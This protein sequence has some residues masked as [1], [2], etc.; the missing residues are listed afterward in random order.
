MRELSL[1]LACFAAFLGMALS[2]GCTRWRAVC[3]A[4]MLTASCAGSIALLIVV[5][6]LW[7]RWR[8]TD[9]EKWT[10]IL[11]ALILVMLIYPSERWRAIFEER[12]QDYPRMPERPPIT[13][14]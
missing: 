6:D 12:E 10:C 4:S 8:F 5:A 11:A 2:S 13:H 7:E 1:A 14:P 9:A 3:F